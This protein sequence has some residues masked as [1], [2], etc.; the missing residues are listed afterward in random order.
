VKRPGERSGVD[1]VA[2][3]DQALDT[4]PR[5]EHPM[6]GLALRSG[7]LWSGSANAPA[8]GIPDNNPR[9]ED[10]DQATLVTSECCDTPS[11]L[12]P[13]RHRPVLDLDMPAKLIPSS[14][15]GHFHLIIDHEMPWPAYRKLLE[16]LAEAGV[17]EWGFAAASINRG[18]SSVRVPWVRKE[19][20][21]QINPATPGCDWRDPRSS[22]GPGRPMFELIEDDEWCGCSACIEARGDD[23]QVQPVFAGG[24][25]R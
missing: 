7:A 10:L 18:Y 23:V 5:R 22:S 8:S 13:P 9:T 3:I 21:P 4:R 24:E 20:P 2:R 15:P 12:G 6:P 25:A 11:W 19:Q 17:I 1:I 14:T 16:A